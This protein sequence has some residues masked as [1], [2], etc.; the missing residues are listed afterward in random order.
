MGE[1]L[2]IVKNLDRGFYKEVDMLRRS[3]PAATSFG[4]LA[5]VAAERG[6]A[7][8]ERE[9][10]ARERK[11]LAWFGCADTEGYRA[12]KIAAFARDTWALELAFRELG[13]RTRGPEADA[14]GKIFSSSAGTVLFPAFVE[15]QVVAGMLLASLVPTMIAQEVT[16]NSHTVEHLAMTDAEADRR[17]SKTGEGAPGATV[18]LRTAERSI[19]L[20]KYA[21]QLDATYES[22]RLQRLN[23]VGLL[24]QRLGEQL[25]IDE[26][27]D[28]IEVAIAGDGNPNSAASVLNTEQDNVLDY[29]DLIRLV[30]RF[31]KGYQMRV[32]I[33]GDETLRIVLNLP[34]FRDANLGDNAFQR[35]HAVQGPL[36]A[37]WQRWTRTTPSFTADR[38][39]ALDSRLALVQYTEQGVMTESDRLIDRQFERTVVSKWSGF[40]KLDY[41]AVQVLDRDWA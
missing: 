26:T 24:L 11:F 30:L 33:A 36:A 34:E 18:T 13:I 17:T 21:A 37:R 8:D 1:I 35:L 25:G 40:G 31:P 29:D 5:A 20:E 3:E 14:L 41:H 38:I 6:L 22:L 19:R 16:V 2:Q 39:L 23:V 28:A 27:D 15:T 4:R 32:A 12:E 7:P 9:R 10:Q